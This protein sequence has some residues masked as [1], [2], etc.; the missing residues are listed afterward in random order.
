MPYIYFNVF[1][2]FLFVFNSLVQKILAVMEVVTQTHKAVTALKTALM[3]TTNMTVVSISNSIHNTTKNLT[4][5]LHKFF[6]EIL[7]T[8]LFSLDSILTNYFLCIPN[9][10]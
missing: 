9:G 5:I 10:R 4:L 8:N 2:F 6:F 7:F 1:V 3:G